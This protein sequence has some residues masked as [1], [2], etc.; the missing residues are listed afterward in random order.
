MKPLVALSLS[1][2]FFFFSGCKDKGEE[3]K[4]HFR[5]VRWGMT[6]KEVNASEN[7][8][9][10]SYLAGRRP[11][12]D[13]IYKG[14]L[15]AKEATLT[16]K[17]RP[18]PDKK[19]VYILFMAVYKIETKRDR[20]EYEKLSREFLKILGDKYGPGARHKDSDIEFVWTLPEKET[21]ILLGTTRKYDVNLVYTDLKYQLKQ[22]E[23]KRQERQR[24]YEETMGDL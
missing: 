20:G 6:K 10:V 12:A 18:H 15:L 3:E 22:P 11:E 1:L 13:L 19:G 2:M 14:E 7:W 24:I 21:I 8:K 4:V 9:D 5:N 17:F 16:Y 23:L